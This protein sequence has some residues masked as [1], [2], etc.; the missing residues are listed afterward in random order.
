MDNMH[1]IVIGDDQTSGTHASG[2]VGENFVKVLFWVQDK[3][4]YI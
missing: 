3:Q 2:S 4:I 1:K